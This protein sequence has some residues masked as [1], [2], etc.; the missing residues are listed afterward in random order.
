MCDFDD[1]LND[2]ENFQAEEENYDDYDGGYEETVPEHK[3]AT[4]KVAVAAVANKKR[5]L[6]EENDF[7][8]DAAD[9][10]KTKPPACFADYFVN[11]SEPFKN[12]S[13][14]ANKPSESYSSDRISDKNSSSQSG[15]QNSND[16]NAVEEK[17]PPCKCGIPSQSKTTLKEGPNKNRKFWV[18]YCLN[19]AYCPTIQLCH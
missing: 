2:A 12:D 3:A 5:T 19:T 16:D 9:V 1:L 18:S 4:E 13:K 14:A 11:T 7:V 6:N 10:K 8:P 15:S 17:G